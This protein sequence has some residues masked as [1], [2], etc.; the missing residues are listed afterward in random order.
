MELHARGATRTMCGSPPDLPGVHAMAFVRMTDLD[1]AG[2]R[3]LIRE[4]E[5]GLS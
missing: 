3:V 2:K 4:G 5:A 1:I